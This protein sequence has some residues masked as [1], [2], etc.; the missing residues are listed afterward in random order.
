MDWF[1]FDKQEGTCGSF[2]SAFVLLARAV[3]LPARVVSGWAIAPTPYVQTV[4]ADQAHQWAEVALNGIG[5][6]DFD[7]TPGGAGSRAALR[8]LDNGGLDGFY[9]SG[10]SDDPDRSGGSGSSGGWLRRLWRLR[11]LR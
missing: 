5:W 1:L 2:S 3:G 9:G 11:W 7:P 10:G 8:A 4:S 6:V